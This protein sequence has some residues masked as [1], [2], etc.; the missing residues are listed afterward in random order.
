MSDLWG[1]RD[2]VA[3]RAATIRSLGFTERQSRFLVTIMI[4]SGVFIERQYCRFAGIA[5]GGDA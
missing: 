3:E 2:L 4:H 5:H 1:F